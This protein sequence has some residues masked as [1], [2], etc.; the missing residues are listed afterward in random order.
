MFLSGA[1]LLLEEVKVPLYQ[2][3]FKESTNEIG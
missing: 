3:D 2:I 1:S